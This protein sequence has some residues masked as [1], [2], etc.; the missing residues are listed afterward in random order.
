[1][2]LNP[3]IYK[4]KEICR[5]TEGRKP[6]ENR[7]RDWSDRATNQIGFSGNHQKLQNRIF[8]GASRRTTLLIP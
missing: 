1:M 4:N 8:L 3:M 2:G 5:D 7:G 6:D